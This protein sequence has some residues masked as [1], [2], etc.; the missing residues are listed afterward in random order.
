MGPLGWAELLSHLLLLLLWL[1]GLLRIEIKQSLWIN[2]GRSP[3]FW[4]QPAS[5]PRFLLIVR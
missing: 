1:C 5:P 4:F 2:R 3:G